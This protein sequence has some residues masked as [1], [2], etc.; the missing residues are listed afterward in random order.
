MRRLSGKATKTFFFSFIPSVL[1][2]LEMS[3]RLGSRVHFIPSCLQLCACVCVQGKVFWVTA[4]SV[5][6]TGLFYK[7][8]S[9]NMELP[10]HFLASLAAILFWCRFAFRLAPVTLSQRE[11]K[12]SKVRS[13]LWSTMSA[14]RGKLQMRW[15]EWTR[16]EDQNGKDD[17][18][19]QRKDRTDGW[20]DGRNEKE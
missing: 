11:K 5:L 10:F 12:G 2:S 20:M 18:M 14:E 9:K 13:V 19:R 16:E 8:I 6:K 4:R 7:I 3:S 17:V 1:C 15:G